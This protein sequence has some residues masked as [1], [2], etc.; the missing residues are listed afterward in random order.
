MFGWFAGDFNTEKQKHGNGMY[1]WMEP[2][3]ESGEP[4]K[5]ASYEGK[6][7][8]GKKNGLGKMTF[9]NG[10]VYFGEWKDNKVCLFFV[11]NAVLSSTL[12]ISVIY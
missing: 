12:T 1:T 9:P 7:A 6:Y 11:E 10:D 4:K 8:D 5:V 2:D 3:E